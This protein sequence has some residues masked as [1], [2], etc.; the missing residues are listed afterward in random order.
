M[1]SARARTR[2]ERDQYLANVRAMAAGTMGKP[3]KEILERGFKTHELAGEHEGVAEILGEASSR[4]D[5][6]LVAATQAIDATV[7]AD[8]DVDSAKAMS[9][10]SI[11]L[12]INI[13]TEDQAQVQPVKLEVFPFLSRIGR[14]VSTM[15]SILIGIPTQV[16]VTFISLVLIPGVLHAQV[17]LTVLCFWAIVRH[18]ERHKRLVD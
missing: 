10:E 18:H 14:V 9:S 8:T 3:S 16:F 1:D 15:A 4:R 6:A 7:R 11:P 17:V 13:A 2:K 12:D 5:A